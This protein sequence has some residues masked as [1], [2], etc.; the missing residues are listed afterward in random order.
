MPRF[1]RWSSAQNK[2]PVKLGE[3]KRF[4]KNKTAE[5]EAR[6]IEEKKTS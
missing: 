5:L 4:S 6:Q 1:F 3:I 2:P